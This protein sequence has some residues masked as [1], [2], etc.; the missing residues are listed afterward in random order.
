M[1]SDE[2]YLQICEEFSGG[3]SSGADGTGCLHKCMVCFM[4]IGLKNNIPYVIKAWPE[5][6]INGEWLKDHLM[7]SIETLQANTGSPL[8]TCPPPL[9]ILLALHP[10]N[11]VPYPLVT[12]YNVRVPALVNIENEVISFFRGDC[13]S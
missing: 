1:I 2:I 10:E 13:Y 11:F 8:V 6:E 5:N 4:I 12:D 9:Y 3:E 7:D